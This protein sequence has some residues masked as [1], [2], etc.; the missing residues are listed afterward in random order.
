MASLKVF[1]CLLIVLM[2]CNSAAAQDLLERARAHAEKYPGTPMLLP[3]SPADYRPMTIEE[4]TRAAEVVVQATLIESQSYVTLQGDRVLTDYSIAN[5]SFLAGRASVLESRG[6]KET[7]ALTLTAFG[8]EV[9]L[10]GVTVR[11]SDFNRKPITPGAEYVLFL[12]PARRQAGKF[13]VYNGGIFEVGGGRARALIKDA[14]RV[15][16]GSADVPLP[17]LRERIQSAAA[18]R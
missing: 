2:T 3:A 13:E 6:V 16:K 15:F 9:V 5:P 10:A 12:R 7:P 8:G 17:S 4:L 11:A 14:D 18:V 1:S